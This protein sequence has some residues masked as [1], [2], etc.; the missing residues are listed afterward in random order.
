MLG[1]HMGI[2]MPFKRCIALLFIITSVA[3]TQRSPYFPRNGAK[4]TDQVIREI[5]NPSAYLVIAL[6]PGFE[7]LA[8]IAN[9]RIGNGASVAVAYVTNGENIPSDVNSEM[10]YQLASRR[11]EEAYQALSY[12]GAQAYFLNIPVNDFS[13]GINCFHPTAALTKALNDRL[14]SVIAQVKPDVV[15][16]DRDPLSTSKGSAR[17]T[18]LEHLIINKLRDT[19][20]SLLWSMKRLFVQTNERKNTAVIPVEQRDAV[21]SKSYDAMGAEAENF[22]ES[23]RYQIPMWKWG[24][25]HSYVQRYPIGMKPPLQLHSGLPDI[26]VKLQTLQPAVSSVN[27]IKKFPTQGKKLEMLRTVIAQVDACIQG[28]GKSMTPTDVRVLT[29]WKLGLEK[30]RCQILNVSIPFSVSDTIVTPIQVFFLRFGALDSV[31]H[32]GKI[33][34]LFPGVIQKQWIVNEAQNNFYDLKDST[35]LRVLSP[36]SIS[37]N[38]TESP[39]GFEAIQ[40]RTPLVFIV[41]HE[42]ANPNRNFMDREEIPLVIAPYRSV[43][44]LSPLVMMYRDT[45]IYVRFKSNVRDKTKGGVY[46]NDAVVSS[47]QKEVELPGKNIVVIDTLRLMWKDTLLTAPHEVT[48]RAGKGISVGSFM[49]RPVDVRINVRTKVSICS[50]IENSPVQVALRRLGVA[51]TL[52]DSANI[53]NTELLRNSVIIVDQCSFDKFLRISKQLDSVE[54]WLSSGGRLIIFPQYGAEPINPFLG[55]DITFTQLSAGDCQEKLFLDSTNV[56]YHLPNKISG[57]GFTEE[58]FPI[59]YSEIA[60]TKSDL[61]RVLMKAGNRVLFLEKRVEKGK[62]FYCAMNLFPRLLDLHKASYELLANLV[63]VE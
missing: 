34:V 45:D 58:K 59:S 36:R 43:E 39:Q 62:I 17:L 7:D 24:G 4:A 10:F 55:N 21:W 40:V 3:S 47:P 8:S 56:V 28:S 14:D 60:A 49:V 6:A 9:F 35:Q 13:A 12:L 48:I 63:S 53:S 61:S 15:V 11:K 41:M 52:L 25:L 54:H 23:L 18:Y 20:T 33:H 1:N 22:Y 2:R 50:T 30:L 38:S 5:N 57:S 31:L 46:I 16:V 42:D 32:S 26:G 44:V 19:T 37:L 29:T 51:A 27:S